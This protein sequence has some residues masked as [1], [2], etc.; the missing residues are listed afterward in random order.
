M[1][2]QGGMVIEVNAGP[3]LQMHSEPQIGQARPVGAAIVETLFPAGQTGRI[4]IVAVTSGAGAAITAQVAA[5]L[6]CAESGLTVGLACTAGTFVGERRLAVS[7]LATAGP[8]RIVPESPDRS[9]RVRDLGQL[10]FTTKVW[11]STNAT[12]RSLRRCREPAGSS[13]PT[14]VHEPDTWRRIV[15]DSVSPQGTLVLAAD[16]S[17]AD[18]LAAFCRGSVLYYDVSQSHPRA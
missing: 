16:D 7:R 5:A 11:H 17:D 8:G 14:D 1:E 12:W 15:V 3:G 18:R 10:P 13:R 6:D 9:G 2:E 4:P